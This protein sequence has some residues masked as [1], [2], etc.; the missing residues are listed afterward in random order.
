MSLNRKK[1]VVVIE[2]NDLLRKA[3][4]DSKEVLIMRHRP[5]ELGLRRVLPWYATERQELFN[6]YQRA[7]ASANAETALS[8]ANY[9]ASFIGIEPGKA[10]FV[11]LYKQNGFRQITQDEYF[12]IPECREL[13]RQGMSA[14]SARALALWFDLQLTDIFSDLRGRLVINWTGLERSWY[15][16]ANRNAFPIN[17]ILE[18]SSFT[19]EMPE[20]RQLV[21][22][23]PELSSLPAAWRTALAQWRGIYLITDKSDGRSYVGSAYGNDNLLRRWVNYAKSGHG[24]NKQLKERKPENFVFAILQR[25]SPDMEINDVIQLE[26]SWKNRLLTRTLGLNSN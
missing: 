15:R 12:A 4:I 1:T 5:T 24:G 23:W 21:L 18:T 19:E 16:W 17:S 14:A 7:Q 20:W 13:H 26:D 6:A 25:V 22:S 10:H 8:R 2:F 3:E 11:G 9:L